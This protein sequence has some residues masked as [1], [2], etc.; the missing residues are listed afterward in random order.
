MLPAAGKEDALRD[1]QVA[2]CAP[3]RTA[4]VIL[5]VGAVLYVGARCVYDMLCLLRVTNRAA[6]DM[7]Q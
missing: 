3:V 2:V 6:F 7:Y 1:V 5:L 4:C